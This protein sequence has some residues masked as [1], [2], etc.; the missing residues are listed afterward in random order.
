MGCLS[1]SP[2]GKLL[3]S[4]CGQ[5][6]GNAQCHVYDTASGREIVTYRGHDNIVLAT[7]FSPDGR[8]AATGG[9]DNRRSTSGTRIRASP[10]PGPMASR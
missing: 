8:W 4:G 7:A 3:L 1:F 2:D 6:C 10:G 9:G 5:R